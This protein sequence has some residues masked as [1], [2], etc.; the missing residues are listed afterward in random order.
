MAG[1]TEALT[2]IRVPTEAEEQSRSVSR[3]R[4]QRLEHRKR[5]AAQGLSCARYYGHDLP[6]EGWRAGKFET[7]R[8][9]LPEFLF[10]LLE[11]VQRIALVVHTR[12]LR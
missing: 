8:P 4:E 3:Q 11:G 2:S 9:E 7:L 5:L 12:S 1:N 6:D 10:T